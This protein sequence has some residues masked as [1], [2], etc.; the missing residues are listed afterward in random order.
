MEYS[1]EQ[2]EAFVA[3]AEEGSF[4]AAAR[5]LG[6]A[7]SAVSTAVS[8]LEIDFGVGLFDRSA[9]LPV[10]SPA[11]ETL[12]R[13]ARLLLERAK[14]LQDRALTMAMDEP[15]IQLAVD[16]ALAYSVVPAV[17][18]RFAEQFPATQVHLR[19]GQMHDISD[20]FDAGEVDCGL[21]MPPT[22]DPVSKG[23]ARLDA[24]L[25]GYVPFIPVCSA[26]NALAHKQNVKREEIAHERQLIPAQRSGD[27]NKEGG[28]FSYNMW[29]VENLMVSLSLVRS[30]LGWAF[31]P[32]YVVRN[33]IESGSLVRIAAGFE[34]VPFQV[35][36]YTLRPADRSMGKAAQWLLAEFERYVSEG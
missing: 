27:T 32:E 11:G 16:E 9:K 24:K 21:L 30:N 33:D 25:I 4:S 5:R 29:F 19:V 1:F 15:S 34:I 28:I 10:L 12:L 22:Q 31:F 7:Q 23:N 35:P 8:N 26:D 6:K 20:M 13:E 2:L 18:S 14:S 17:L 36:I 3:T